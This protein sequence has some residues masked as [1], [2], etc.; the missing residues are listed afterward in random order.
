MSVYIFLLTVPEIDVEA[1][2]CCGFTE[3][4]LVAV[5]NA[6]SSKQPSILMV[7]MKF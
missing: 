7:L 6:S 4:Q 2:Y 1:F 3:I 5:A